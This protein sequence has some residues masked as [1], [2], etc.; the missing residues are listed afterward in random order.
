LILDPDSFNILLSTLGA[1]SPSRGLR[2][3]REKH[4]GRIILTILQILS[5]TFPATFPPGRTS[6]AMDKSDSTITV[7]VSAYKRPKHLWLNLLGL[8]YQTVRPGEIVVADDGSGEEVRSVI[9]KFA[10]ESKMRVVHVWQPH[11]DYRLA[12]SRN[13]AIRAARGEYL[14]F[15]DQDCIAT[16]DFVAAHVTGGRLGVFRAGW[17]VFLDEE[18]SSRLTEEAIREGQFEGLATAEEMKTL[19]KMQRKDNFYAFLRRR[20]WP[21]KF[22][23]KLRGGNFSI[24]K[25][26]LE[27]VNGFDENFVGWGQED[28]DLGRRLYLAGIIGESVVASAITF[29]LHHPPPADAKAR[30]RDGRNVQYF[31]REEVPSFAENGLKKKGGQPED[32]VIRICG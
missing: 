3:R 25:A 22:K 24:H 13:N 5:K 9:E 4:D 16:P 15:I 17:C 14:V 10:A 20:L 26:D 12:R 23:P 30:W 28:D 32:V 19:R 31:L 7:I 2:V 1:V 18:R 11:E 27:K 21:I 8:S 29:H 6:L